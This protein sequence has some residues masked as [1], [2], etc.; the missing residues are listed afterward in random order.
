MKLFNVYANKLSLSYSPVFK[1]S[2]LASKQLPF[3][4]GVCNRQ[5]SG[6]NPARQAIQCGSCQH[7]FSSSCM[8]ILIIWQFMS[9][10]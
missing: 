8:K 4:P 10:N 9:K 7:W 2:G 3:R 5:P 6:H 1:S